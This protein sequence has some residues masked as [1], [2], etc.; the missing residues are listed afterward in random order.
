MF[1]SSC[2]KQIP[3]TVS[4]CPYCGKPAAAPARGP[5][6][7]ATPPLRQTAVSRPQIIPRWLLILGGSLIGLFLLAVLFFVLDPFNLNLIGRFTGRYDAALTAMP[8]DT[9]AY[10]G[11]NLLAAGRDRERF[12]Q[13]T[14][15]F[16]EAAADAGME[17]VGDEF[18]DVTNSKQGKLSDDDRYKQT[19]SEFP[20]GMTPVLYVNLEALLDTIRADLPRDDRGDFDET[21]VLFAPIT[22]IAMATET[23]NSDMGRQTILLFIDTE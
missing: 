12:E 22:V 5:A 16:Q 14:T 9:Y 21:A 6:S 13:I 10:I 3:D 11:L 15:T 1:C 23:G 19:W 2:G 20:R 18:E 8:P 4:F 17:D 7:P